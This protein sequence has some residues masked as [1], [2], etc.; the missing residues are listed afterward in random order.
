[1]RIIPGNFQHIGR[2]EEQQDAFGFSDIDD[3]TSVLNGGVMAIVA[4]GMGGLSCGRQASQLAVRTMLY[5]YYHESCRTSVPEALW[6]SVHKANTAIL[7]LAMESNLAGQTGTTLAAAVIYR[8]M[9]F[10]VTVGDSRVYLYRQG[11]LT[12]LNADHNYRLDLL[13]KSAQ[14]DF[15]RKE[16]EAHAEG[17]HLTSYLGLTDLE[18]I[19]R[20]IRPYTLFAGDRIL[21]CSDGFYANLSEQEIAEALAGDPQK[22]CYVLADRV[23]ALNRPDQ[24]NLT[25]AILA[26]EKNEPFRVTERQLPQTQRINTIVR[27]RW[28][29]VALLFFIVS[30]WMIIQMANS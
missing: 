7:Q 22:A 8:D 30:A 13:K 19:D 17:A 5:E 28:G 11:K 4:D 12:R 15:G 29:A 26:L 3:L 21:L 25:V 24:D 1:M 6:K 18:R 2:R 14:G 23:L 16:A 9:L 10:W 27:F 20:N